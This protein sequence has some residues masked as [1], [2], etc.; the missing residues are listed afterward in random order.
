MHVSID[1]FLRTRNK[2][3]WPLARDKVLSSVVCSINF[4]GDSS[5]SQVAILKIYDDRAIRNIR[6]S[7]G[8]FFHSR[9][10]MASTVS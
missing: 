9:S 2:A 7:Q 6:Q 3:L 5:L 1:A 10:M 8:V 4:R